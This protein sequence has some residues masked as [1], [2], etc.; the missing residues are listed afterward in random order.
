MLSNLT[1]HLVRK[2]FRI[3]EACVER[4]TSFRSY[5]AKDVIIHEIGPRKEERPLP[6]P[7]LQPEPVL[8]TCPRDFAR[9]AQTR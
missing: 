8:K 5:M 1:E 7:R 6:S 3:C 2:T 4:S 9:W